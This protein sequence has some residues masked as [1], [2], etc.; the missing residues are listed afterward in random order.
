MDELIENFRPRYEALE[1]LSREG[2]FREKGSA[3]KAMAAYERAADLFEYLF[4][5]KE[6]L[7]TD[8]DAGR[9]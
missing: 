6:T 8:S 1:A 7:Q 9:S 5:T 3:K 2:G 4:S